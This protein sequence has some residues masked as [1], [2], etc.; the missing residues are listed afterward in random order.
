M[1]YLIHL[2]HCGLK[3][4]NQ[5]LNDYYLPEKELQNNIYEYCDIYTDELFDSMFNKF[6]GVKN[7]YSRLFFDPERFSD[8]TQ[9]EMYKK[10]RLG[11]FYENAIIDKKPLR[12][13]DNK[14]IIKKYYDEH[15]KQ[16]D[17]LTQQKLDIFNRCTIIDCHSFSD[18]EYWFLNK[19][20]DFPDI[21]IGYE[22]YHM[23]K[24]LIEIIKEEFSEY[25]IGLNT[26]YDGSLVP[27]KYWHK[28]NRVKSVMIEIN[29][30]IYTEHD[31]KTKSK[32]FIIM[33]NKIDNILNKITNQRS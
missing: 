6:G 28:D 4:P 11:W 8:D 24:N 19:A 9:E 20:S 33:K 32:N 22:E 23:D 31:N 5:F 7:E 13:L 27:M 21:C 12:K 25:K 10:Y 2:P 15:H 1:S 14:D 17:N 3:I 29:K 30:R 18:K 16:L 26:P